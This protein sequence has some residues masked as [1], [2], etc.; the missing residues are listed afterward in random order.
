M[1]CGSSLIYIKNQYQSSGGFD[2]CMWMYVC[3]R[4]S[5]R[6]SAMPALTQGP[7]A[8]W[9]ELSWWLT[10]KKR[11]KSIHP[12]SSS[13]HLFS[14]PLTL[15]LFLYIKKGSTSFHSQDSGEHFY[16]RVH[17]PFPF[18]YSP[19]QQQLQCAALH[20]HIHRTNK[21]NWMCPSGAKP[22]M[23]CVSWNTLL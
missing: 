19:L 14:P 11:K 2:L 5:G 18:F 9:K 6:Q 3:V 23:T 10:E 17:F 7:Q 16:S 15:H 4:W 21:V 12:H 1:C 8:G 22:L 20:K 13:L